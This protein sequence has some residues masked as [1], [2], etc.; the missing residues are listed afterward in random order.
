[1]DVK[2]SK[3]FERLVIEFAANACAS[4]DAVREALILSISCCKGPVLFAAAMSIEFFAM[5]V[6]LFCE[7]CCISN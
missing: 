2:S 5:S 3:L 7:S 6:C 4:A 1:M